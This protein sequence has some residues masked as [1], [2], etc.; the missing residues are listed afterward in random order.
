MN[1]TY[2]LAQLNIA[3]LLA[4]IDDP[5]IKAFVDN[6]DPINAIADQADGFVWRLQTEDGNATDI[7]AFDDSLII[8]NMS[9]WQDVASLKAYTYQSDHVKIM[10]RR[11]EWFEKVKEMH[12]VMWWVPIG[13]HPTSAE[14]KEKLAYLEKHGETAVAFTFKTPFPPPNSNE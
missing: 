11:K 10:R 14:A 2:H 6:L 4:P 12:F 1:Q 5:K 8:V 7:Q 9:V 3:R 13:Q